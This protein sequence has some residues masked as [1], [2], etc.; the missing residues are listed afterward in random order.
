M[1]VPEAADGFRDTVGVLW[2]VVDSQGVS[3]H[4][5]LRV[6]YRYVRLLLTVIS[7]CTPE[8]EI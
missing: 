3:L 8:A 7:I 4:T 1:L 5:F 2:A 6:E